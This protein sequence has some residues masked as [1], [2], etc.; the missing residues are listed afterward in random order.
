[1][2]RTAIRDTDGT[3][4]PPDGGD[5]PGEVG[6]G[7]GAYE[8]VLTDEERLELRRAWLAAIRPPAGRTGR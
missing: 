8:P 1:V 2:V 5:D 6:D 3:E 4:A 7:P